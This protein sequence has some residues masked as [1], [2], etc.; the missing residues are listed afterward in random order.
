MSRRTTFVEPRS[1]SARMRTGIWV[2]L[3]LLLFP[4][5]GE[6]TETAP[7]PSPSSSPVACTPS[8]KRVRYAVDFTQPV[9]GPVTTVTTLIGYPAD[10]LSLPGTGHDA[11]TKERITDAP[12]GAIVGSFDMDSSVRVTLVKSR[13]LE[14]GYL[15][16]LEF[17]QCK[18][19]TVPR[20]EDLTC[21][22]EACATSSGLQS[23][24]SC[25]V[26]EASAKQK[27]AKRSRKR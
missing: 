2:F 18:G 8:G 13:S 25:R 9:A 1:R 11:S 19:A 15:F 16:V 12:S 27:P 4:H 14:S 24:C 10:R 21:T 7:V 22:M 5:V 20:P 23:G 26:A 17:D 3:T 6:G